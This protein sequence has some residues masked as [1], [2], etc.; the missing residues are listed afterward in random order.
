[1][2]ASVKDIQEDIINDIS[3]K[4]VDQ[5]GDA[6]VVKADKTRVMQ[7]ISNLLVNAIKFTEKG[8]IVI[9]LHNTNTA[10]QKEEGEQVG[11]REII[12]S[13]KDSGTGI[14]PEM[15]DSYLKNLQQNQTRELD[16][17]SLFVES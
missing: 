11:E 9:G 12:V 1:M 2:M 6:F 3:G 14:D 16:L 17:V 7:V 10:S 4:I 15:K 8:K 5:G 13:F